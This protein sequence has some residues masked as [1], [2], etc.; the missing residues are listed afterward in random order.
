[1]YAR[2][3]ILAAIIAAT[4]CALAT[5]QAEL[6]IS[7]F[8][9]RIFV[10]GVEIPVKISIRNATPQ[11]W[12]FKLADEK[13]LS[14]SFDIRSLSNRPLEASDSWKR[15]M[16]SSSPAFYRELALQPGEEYSFVEDLRN[17]VA[18]TEPGTYVVRCTLWPELGSLSGSAPFLSSNALTLSVRPGLPVPGAV[19]VYR[20]GTA[21]ILRAE[22]IGPDEVVNRTIR[23]RQKNLWNEFF[24]YLDLERLLRNNQDKRRSYDRESDDG[25]RRMLETYRTDLMQSVVDSDI[26]VIP[27]SFEITETRYG[28]LY[29]TV[30]VIQKFAYDGFKMIKEYTYELEKQDDIWYIVAYMVQNKGTE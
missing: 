18:V 20:A 17:F 22:R 28:P 1:V 10:P 29:G 27:S 13:R 19:E 12:R 25:R 21:D 16:A 23:A 3:T 2:R 8:D 9:K 24:L 26:V 11:A 15:A 7:F 14:V 4:V 5:A 6:S 30:T